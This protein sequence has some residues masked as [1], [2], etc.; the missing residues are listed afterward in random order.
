MM[1]HMKYMSE[2]I[3]MIADGMSTV[4]EYSFLCK[5]YFNIK[6]DDNYVLWDLMLYG[7]L[8]S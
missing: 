2:I 7:Q 6:I 5:R 3:N 1:D 8:T 4:I